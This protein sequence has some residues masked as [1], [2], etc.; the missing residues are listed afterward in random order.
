MQQRQLGRSGFEVSALGFGCMA[1]SDFY[2][3]RDEREALATIHRAIERGVNFFDTA[4]IYGL[5]RNEELVGR[6]IF[7]R[8]ECVVLATKC[9]SVRDPEPPSRRSGPWRSSSTKERSAISA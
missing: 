7:D 9:G 8:R 6:A 3:P 5:G 4:N 1:M 2:G